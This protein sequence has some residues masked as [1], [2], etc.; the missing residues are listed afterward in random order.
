MPESAARR[1]SE[2]AAA[3]RR[4]ARRPALL[5]GG[6]RRSEDRPCRE[7]GHG[8]RRSAPALVGALLPSLFEGDGKQAKGHPGPH[9]KPA[10]GALAVTHQNRRAG[11]GAIATCPPPKEAAGTLRSARPTALLLLRPHR[12]R[13]ALA[14]APG[15]DERQ[16]IP[17]RLVEQ[18]RLLDVHRVAAL[19]E[20]REARGRDVFLEINARLDAGVVL[21]AADDQGRQRDLPD[22]RLELVERRPTG[23]IAAQRAGSAFGRMA[24]ELIVE[25]AVAARVLDLEGNARR[26]H[27]VTLRHT[28]RA[29]LVVFGRGRPR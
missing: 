4:K 13:I 7:A 16:K 25:L 9:E 15:I 20:N 18:R 14:P 28:L 22:L 8:V 17:Q 27:A 21:V 11:K 10:G 19:R 29:H 2:N 26:A 3:E 24:R 5:A 6:L 23:L 12:A 1:R